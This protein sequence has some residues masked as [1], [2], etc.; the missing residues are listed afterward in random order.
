MSEEGPSK[1]VSIEIDQKILF[2][3][4]VPFVKR[5]LSVKILYYVFFTKNENP[6]FTKS[7]FLVSSFL[8][9]TVHFVNQVFQDNF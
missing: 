1:T 4:K 2:E 3:H 9:N 6:F 5:L 7:S 8:C